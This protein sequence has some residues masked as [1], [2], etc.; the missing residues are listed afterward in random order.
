M[1]WR[2]RKTQIKAVI[3]RSLS[4]RLF[5]EKA[6]CLCPSGINLPS[7]IFPSLEK[8][9]IALRGIMAE[10]VIIIGW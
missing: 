3:C 1:T 4:G 7:G 10:Q 9:I 5:T 8:N 2:K 6:G